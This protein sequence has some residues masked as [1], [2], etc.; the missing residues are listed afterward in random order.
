MR[1]SVAT[2][3]TIVEASIGPYRGNGGR[4]SMFTGL[5][6]LVGWDS[7]ESQQRYP[8][9]VSERNTQVRVL[10]NSPDPLDALRVISRYGVRYI[11]VGP[12][13]RQ[14]EFAFNGQP[15][16]YASRE[17]V[18]KF[19]AMVGETLDVA[20]RNAGVTI[21]KVRPSTQWPASAL[22]ADADG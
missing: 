3:E 12:V 14:H 13:E 2:P 6:T 7:H 10:Y 18:A 1:E 22:S 16:P 20:Y 9:P 4:I 17:G 5:P 11:Y 19:E 8:E 15:E 21:Y